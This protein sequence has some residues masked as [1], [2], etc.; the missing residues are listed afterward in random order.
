MISY[1]RDT[2]PAGIWLREKFQ[3]SLRLVNGRLIVLRF[4]LPS[5]CITDGFIWDADKVTK[6]FA[7]SILVDD[8]VTVEKYL[9]TASVIAD[10]LNEKME[11]EAEEILGQIKM[12]FLILDA[13]ETYDWLTASKKL[14]DL[15]DRLE[16]YKPRAHEVWAQW[17]RNILHIIRSANKPEDGL[18]TVI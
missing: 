18:D 12:S 14:S 2:N 7:D 16:S 15:C 11:L 13:L 10:T 8:V 9:S 1:L 5:C 3:I 4:D 17:I 6:H